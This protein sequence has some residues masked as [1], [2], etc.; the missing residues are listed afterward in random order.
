MGVLMHTHIF[1]KEVKKIPKQFVGAA[2]R[3]VGLCRQRVLWGSLDIVF[4]TWWEVKGRLISF[5]IVLGWIFATM[6]CARG[7]AS[8]S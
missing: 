7:W 8:A 4:S 5:V 6:A 2:M 3:A 1:E